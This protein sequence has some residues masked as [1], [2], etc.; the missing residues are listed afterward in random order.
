MLR[1]INDTTKLYNGVLMPW[2]GLGVWQASGDDVINAVKWAVEAGYRHIDTA[3]IYG[4]EKEVGIGLKEC[5]VS[6]HDLFV[7]S[8]LLHHGYESAI[9]SCE[10]TLRD[11]QTDYLDLYLIHWPRPKEGKYI[12]SWKGLEKLYKDGKVR[13]IGVANF[14]DIWIKEIM[15]QCEI[16]PMV[17][18]FEYHPVYQMRELQ[19]FCKDNE[20]QYEAYSP[21]GGGAVLKDPAIK[22]IADKYGKTPAQAILRFELQTGAVVIPKSIHKD[23]IVSNMDLFDFALSDEDMQKFFAMDKNIKITCARPDQD[24]PDF[25]K[26][27]EER[28]KAGMPY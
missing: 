16:K 1:S 3:S 25:L 7:T 6:R 18:Q 27:K 19:Q 9:T 10:E 14:Y 2:V 22:A 13:A 24:W 5:G 21:L 23:R 28:M 26:A 4:N 11:L 20:I 17:N 12:E 15:E 8:K